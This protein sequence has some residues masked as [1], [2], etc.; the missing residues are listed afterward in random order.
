VVLGVQGIPL[1]AE[2]EGLLA[3]EKDLYFIN[4]N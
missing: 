1:I 2:R 4:L 3:A